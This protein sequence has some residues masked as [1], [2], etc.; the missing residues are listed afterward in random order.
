[1]KIATTSDE[2]VFEATVDKWFYLEYKK[3]KSDHSKYIEL[4]LV[5]CKIEYAMKFNIIWKCLRYNS[6]QFYYYIHAVQ[7]PL[8][9]RTVLSILKIKS[10]IRTWR[11]SC[12][13]R[14]ILHVSNFGF[15]VWHSSSIIENNQHYYS[16]ENN[17]NHNHSNYNTNTTFLIIRLLLNT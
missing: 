11:K 16:Y 5:H 8:T 14:Y 2:K 12:R 4:I 10:E 17:R 1:M 13:I 3:L 15:Q 7:F 9:I 6:E